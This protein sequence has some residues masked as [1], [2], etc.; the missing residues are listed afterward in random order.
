MFHLL[1]PYFSMFVPTNRG[2]RYLQKKKKRI[3]HSNNMNKCKEEIQKISI[4]L[5]NKRKKRKKYI[6]PRIYLFTPVDQERRIAE[7]EEELL[8]RGEI[9]PSGRLR[10]SADD[11]P[12]IGW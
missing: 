7:S 12:I 1:G 3:N 5:Q 8:L 6:G 4:I 11:L 2:F 10:R 9:L